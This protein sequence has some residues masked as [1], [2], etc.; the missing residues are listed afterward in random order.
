MTTPEELR[1]IVNSHFVAVR[2]GSIRSI[3]RQALLEAAD[4]I[5]HL[6]K[7]NRDCLDEATAVIK[8]LGERLNAGERSSEQGAAPVLTKQTGRLPI[9]IWR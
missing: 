9:D 8:S 6:H 2:R 5:E 3:I 7:E 4:E 1:R